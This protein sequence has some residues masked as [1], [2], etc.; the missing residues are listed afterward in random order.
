M[1]QKA[2]HYYGEIAAAKEHLELPEPGGIGKRKPK[3]EKVWKE[4][5][6]GDRLS[7]LIL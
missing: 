1:K 2:L 7:G 4:K 6:G 5:R 3:G